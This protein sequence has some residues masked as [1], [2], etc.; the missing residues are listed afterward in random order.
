MDPPELH[1]PHRERTGGR[2]VDLLLTLVAVLVSGVSLYVAVDNGRSMERLVAAN[3]WP[4]LA[5]DTSVLKAEGDAGVKLQI[6][7]GNNGV[8]PA[9]LETLEFFNPQ[10]PV[11]DASAIGAWVK[12]LGDGKPLSAQVQ[13][14]TVVGNV[15]GVGEES[16]IIALIAPDEAT[17]STPF[18][19]AATALETRI[20]YCSVFDDCYVSD[21]RRDNGRPERMTRCPRPVSSY[22][23]DVSSLILG[24]ARPPDAADPD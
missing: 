17:W 7:I 23:D 12:T 4:N 22:D 15:I 19:A 9:R 16:L 14:G 1:A 24:P 11:T 2:W 3:S 21:S 6:E 18:V 13:G 8:G 5:I 20:C 10:G